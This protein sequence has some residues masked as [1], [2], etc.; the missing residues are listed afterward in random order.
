[1]IVTFYSYK[2]GVGRT[3]LLSNIASYLCYYKQ[4]KVLIID[5]DME[6][7]GVDFFFKLNRKKIKAGLLELFSEYNKIVRSNENIEEADLPKMLKGEKYSIN[8]IK[9]EQGNGKVDLI[10]AGKYDK[11]YIKNVNEFD[12]YDFYENLD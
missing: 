10:P 1:M 5:W 7:P 4:R 9:S 12:W 6:A 11:C 2:G 8:L 3:Q